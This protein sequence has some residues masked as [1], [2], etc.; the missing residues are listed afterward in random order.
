VHEDGAIAKAMG[1]V[2]VLQSRGTLDR[3][4][5]VLE[6]ARSAGLLVAHVRIAPELRPA[7]VAGRGPFFVGMQSS[8]S[9]PLDSGEW[10]AAFF[11]GL[12]PTHEELVV[13]KFPISAFAN[14]QL[15]GILTQRRISDLILT[16]VAT[17]MVVDST[18]RAAVDLGYGVIIP[19]DAVA[20]SSKEGH[21]GSINNLRI[22][23]DITSSDALS[24]L[25]RA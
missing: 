19:E 20:A 5:S 22:L 24:S 3:I 17:N 18:A 21:E 15:D 2:D 10:G 23:V 16:G 6:A 1:F 14:S 8:S 11:D 9:S 7:R 25:L 12:E 4:R 13:G